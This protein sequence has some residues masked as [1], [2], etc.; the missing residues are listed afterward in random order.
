MNGMIWRPNPKQETALRLRKVKELFYG[1]ARGGGKTAFLLADFLAGANEWGENWNGIFF[2]QSYS[3]LEDVIRQAKRMYLPLGG[4]Y[5]KA[6]NYFSFPNG[7]TL[8]FRYLES[9]TDCESYQG[10]EYTWIGFDELGNYRTDYAWTTMMMCL[11]SS[12]VPGEWVRIRGTGNPGGVGHKWLKQRFVEGRE[13]CKVYSETVGQDKDGFPAT[14][15]RAFVPATVRDNA[16]LL[17]ADPSYIS[18]LMSQPERIRLATLEGRWDIKGGGEFFDCFDETRHVIKPRLLSGVWHRFYALDWGFKTPYAVVKLAVDK[19]GRVIVY[20]ELYGQG[21]VEGVEKENAGSKE[22]SVQ[23]A[24]KAAADM[25]LEGVTEMA[26]DSSCWDENDYGGTVATA[27]LEQGITLYK[28]VKKRE[29]GWQKVLDL[30]NEKDESGAPC[31]RIFSTCK[32]LIREM[33]NIQCDKN[34]PEVV[35]TRQAD[36]ALDALRYGLMS[37]L[38]G[39]HSSYTPPI[40]SSADNSGSYSVG[41]TSSGYWKKGCL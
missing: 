36:H 41:L 29:A 24:A 8:K 20:G 38:Y 35:D 3:Q 16:A 4:E 5:H 9:D 32:Y 18:R 1:G 14:V 34:N 7:A 30:M 11:R 22:S 39:Y 12:T 2:R 27:F 37:D 17:T 25:A 31:L 40:P 28:A 19:D 26:A 21:L 15:T 33:E 10:H 13:P 6:E 23:V